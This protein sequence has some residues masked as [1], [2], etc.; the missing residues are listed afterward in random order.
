MKILGIESSGTVASVA[1]YDDGKIVTEYTTNFKLTHSQT[2]LPMIDEALKRVGVDVSELD[3]V[4]ISEGPGSYT[5]LRI[6]A[7]TAKGIGLAIG[8]NLVSVSTLKALAFNIAGFDGVICPM[9][10]AKHNEVFSGIYRIKVG[11]SECVR[12][13]RPTL[14]V[15]LIEELNA[16]GEAVMFV[17]DGI[18][19]YKD[20]IDEKIKVEHEYAPTHV[21]LQRASCV[22][23]AAVEMIENGETVSAQMMRPEYLKKSQAEQKRND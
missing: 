7:A 1:L 15:D 17:G 23:L 14:V 2:L 11:K 16:L 10:D 20:V 4:A 3:Y 6:G 12:V 5:G 13:D 21:A 18:A 22:C 8:K 9:I 19:A